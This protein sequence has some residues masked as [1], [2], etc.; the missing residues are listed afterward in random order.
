MT[1]CENLILNLEFSFRLEFFRIIFLFIVST[2]GCLVTFYSQLYI[3]S[4][5][6]KKYLFLLLLF[7]FSIILLSLSCSM[8][9][10][11]MGWDFL[12]LRSIFLIIFYPNKITSFNRFLT[13]YFNR[14]RDIFLIISF[15]LLLRYCPSFFYFAEI[16]YNFLFTIIICSFIKRA[17]Y[18]LFSWLPAAI[19]APTPISALVHSSTLVT[20]GILILFKFILEIETSP[21]Y[22]L[23]LFICLLGVFLGGFISFFE[24][25]L[26]KIVAYSTISQIRVII[27]L[28][29]LFFL[30]VALIHIIFHSFFKSF[31]FVIRGF[32]FIN[33]FR[34]QLRFLFKLNSNHWLGRSL[35]VSIFGMTGLIFSSSFWT[36]DQILEFL[37]RESC[38]FT[39]FLFFLSRIL[40]IC[41]CSKIF[42][43]TLGKVSIFRSFNSSK[44][45]GLKINFIIF[46]ILFGSVIGLNFFN[47]ENFFCIYFLDLTGLILILTLFFLVKWYNLINPLKFILRM[48]IFFTKS[49]IF[50]YFR[51]FFNLDRNL[52]I[53]QSDS[54]FFSKSLVYLKSYN[55]S[56]FKKDLFLYIIF[57]FFIFN[58]VYSFSL[59]WT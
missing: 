43:F 10:L 42:N 22:S 15:S 46:F 44:F 59:N 8:G 39:F 7:I 50:S 18:P 27:F 45:G 13:F 17:Q 20:A 41:Y 26:K 54:F 3:V 37:S 36:K 35:F 6:N 24:L 32:Y 40:T 14:L 58:F 21:F 4:Y 48:D 12:G 53:F 1:Y 25:D 47:K 33:F 31:L 55:F 9:R 34:T 5:N 49:I 23:V 29:S 19:S 57:F 30:D 52:R 56:F 11:S 16:E 38:N 28:G 2:V 51:K